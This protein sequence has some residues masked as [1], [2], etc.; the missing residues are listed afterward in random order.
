MTG[1]KRQPLKKI[2]EGEDHR[3]QEKDRKEKNTFEKGW[4]RKKHLQ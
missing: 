1:K 4:E 2:L 3:L